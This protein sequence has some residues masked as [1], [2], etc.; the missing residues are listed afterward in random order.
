MI[1]MIEVVKLKICW[2]TCSRASHFLKELMKNNDVVNL[3]DS[4]R[5]YISKMKTQMMEEAFQ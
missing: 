4:L 1:I 2:F 5:P 3:R